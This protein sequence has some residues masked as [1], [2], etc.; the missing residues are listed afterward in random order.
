MKHSQKSLIFL[1]TLSSCC[2]VAGHIGVE[3]VLLFAVHTV[4]LFSVNTVRLFIVH[5]VLTNIFRE[6]WPGL[7]ISP[8]IL[9]PGPIFLP[10]QN[11]CDRS[12]IKYMYTVYFLFAA[13]SPA[14]RNGGT[15]RGSTSP[16][17][18]CPSGYKGSYC[19]KSGMHNQQHAHMRAATGP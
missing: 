16:Y 10:D 2:A 14:C 9:V 18:D 3:K 6:K 7:T 13:C 5:A 12:I 8:G 1:S 15:C 19:Q 11:F 17:C 4:C